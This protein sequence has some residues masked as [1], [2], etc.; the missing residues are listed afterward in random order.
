[1]KFQYIALGVSCLIASAAVQAQT[2]RYPQHAISLTVP[3]GAGGS[4]D[5]IA[6]KFATMLERELG[7]SI[8]IQNQPGGAGTLQMR[9]LARAEPDGYTLGFYSY[10]TATFTSQILDVPYKK[11]DFDLLGGIAEFSYG[12]VAVADSPINNMS[13]LVN[14][15][16]TSK[17][18]F[19]GVTGAPNNFPFLQ[20]GKI[21]GGQFDQVTYKSSAESINAVIGGYVDVALQGASEYAELVR[22]G[23]LKVI[24]SATNERLP[25]FPNVPTMKEQGFDIGIK[26]IIGI[27]APK[28]TPAAVKARLEAAIH[29][30]VTADEYEDYLVKTYGIKTYPASAA[31]FSAYIDEGFPRMRNMIETYDIKGL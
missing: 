30:V 1:M 2:S 20:L 15:S 23:K 25:W 17:G 9:N 18:V 12:I 31:E 29:S 6:R 21:T 13:D 10:S 24:A 7:Q 19:Y 4:T 27:A 26:G 8:I 11:A 14:Q 16:K 5:G 22:S 28:G 3:Y